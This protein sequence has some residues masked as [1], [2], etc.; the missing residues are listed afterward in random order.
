MPTCSPALT[1]PFNILDWKGLHS[2]QSLPGRRTICFGTL[3][4]GRGATFWHPRRPHSQVGNVIPRIY[5][6]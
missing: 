6:I 1:K 3:E 5:T 2:F 4:L